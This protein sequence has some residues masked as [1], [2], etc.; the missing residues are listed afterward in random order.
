M[1]AGITSR[2]VRSW[3]DAA[4]KGDPRYE[5]VAQVIRVA[6]ALAEATAVGHVRAAG[7][8]PRF[9]AAEMT[10]LERKNPDRW[11]RRAEDTSMPRV[12]VQV[13]I[14]TADVKVQFSSNAPAASAVI[15]PDCPSK[16]RMG[17]RRYANKPCLNLCPPSVLN[18]T[19]QC[20]SALPIELT[21]LDCRIGLYEMM[22]VHRQ[23]N[24]ILATNQE[25]AGSSPAGPIC[26]LNNFSNLRRR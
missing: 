1:L 18:G 5:P 22:R 17:C 3:M 23:T 13:G 14:A 7:K 2:S 12:V 20:L 26:F 8:D 21:F 16:G 9:W 11:A 19:K 24:Q 10:Y 4:E 6:E 25:V 15:D